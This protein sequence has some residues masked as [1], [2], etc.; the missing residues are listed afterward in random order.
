MRCKAD[1]CLP[2]NRSSSSEPAGFDQLLAVC[3]CVF[4]LCLFIII[5]GRLPSAPFLFFFSRVSIF[6]H[7]SIV[8]SHHRASSVYSSVQ[9]ESES[10]FCH[11]HTIYSCFLCAHALVL[12]TFLPVLVSKLH[13]PATHP[14]NG[15]P[16]ANRQQDD[17]RRP[18]SFFFCLWDCPLPR[19]SFPLVS[20]PL[21]GAFPY[22]LDG[23][24]SSLPCAAV[25]NSSSLFS[26][27]QLFAVANREEGRSLAG[28]ESQLPARAHR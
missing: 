20:H 22:W 17:S 16:V 12:P 28:A 24:L 13:H 8:P 7:A 4:S 14:A 1:G 25:A 26:C 3:V 15:A 2:L 6:F 27:T 5:L 9:S 19:G 11:W 18:P 23:W 10:S 21:E